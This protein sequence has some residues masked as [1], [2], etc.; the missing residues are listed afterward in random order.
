MSLVLLLGGARS[1]KSSLA[2]ELACDAGGHV[3][4]VAPAEARDEEMR[5]R[6]RRH[7]A[8]RPSGWTTV[9][10]P[11]EVRR[12]LDAIEPAETVVVDCLSLWVSNLLERGWAD[13]EVEEEAVD[14]ARLAASRPG[15][16]VAV[17]NEAG[18]GVVPATPLGR[19]WRDLLGRV[20]ER[21][22]R[23]AGEVFLVVAGRVVP[24][25][26]ARV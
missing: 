10:E 11:V 25:G 7:R 14:I 18:L 6:I 2:V 15:L 21:W 22:A 5:E 1:G 24:L 13:D 20:N 26:R 17:S 19:R 8:D 16:C 12:V 9:E 4:F 23:E 3:T